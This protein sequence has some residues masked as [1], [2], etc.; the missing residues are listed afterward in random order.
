MKKKRRQD[1]A[2]RCCHELIRK[3]IRRLEKA[4]A[5]LRKEYKRHDAIEQR[6]VQ[7]F[8]CLDKDEDRVTLEDG[9][10]AVLVDNFQR[11]EIRGARNAEWLL[12]RVKHFEIAVLR[13]RRSRVKHIE[14]L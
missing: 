14:G 8:Q 2:T 13:S 3:D 6:L 5:R 1:R 4:R 7:H 12:V 10:I 9:R 11:D